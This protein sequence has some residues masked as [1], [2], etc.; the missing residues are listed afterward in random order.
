VKRRVQVKWRGELCEPFVPGVAELRPPL[1][2]CAQQKFAMAKAEHQKAMRTDRT[3]T[4]CKIH[5]KRLA[6]FRETLEVRTEPALSV[7]EWASSRRFQPG[8]CF[9]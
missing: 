2:V 1:A 3:S 5:G 7:V 8:R 6:A 9:K 4:S